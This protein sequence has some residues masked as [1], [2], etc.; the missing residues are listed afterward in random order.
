[1]QVLGQ[2]LLRYLSSKADL[3]MS[4]NEA[5]Y[6]LAAVEVVAS[7]QLFGINRT[8]LETLFHRIFSSAQLD[9]VIHDRFA[10]PVKPNEWFLVPLQV[11]DEAVKRIRDGSITDFVYDPKIASLVFNSKK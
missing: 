7:Y 3:T 9:L 4:I 8:K 5:T 10:H 11:I 6:L 2:L 1:M